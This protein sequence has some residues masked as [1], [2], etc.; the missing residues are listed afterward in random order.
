MISQGILNMSIIIYQL[1]QFLH[2]LIVIV[3]TKYIEKIILLLLLGMLLEHFYTY[4]EFGSIF[5][6]LTIFFSIQNG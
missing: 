2:Y 5:G 3:H 4:S 6:F 1:Q